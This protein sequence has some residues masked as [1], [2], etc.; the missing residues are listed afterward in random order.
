M[1]TWSSDLTSNWMFNSLSILGICFQKS[2]KDEILE[3]W[4]LTNLMRW[5][6]WNTD[7]SGFRT[8][9]FILFL[10]CQMI[11]DLYFNDG[12][13]NWK[14]WSNSSFCYINQWLCNMFASIT[15]ICWIS[16]LDV[17]ILVISINFLYLTTSQK[18]SGVDMHLFR[19]WQL[20]GMAYFSFEL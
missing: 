16:R 9:F 2:L 3:W 18:N 6:F 20:K 12:T 13:L 17:F 5:N 7:W 4:K 10:W 19:F 1:Y 14:Y 8:I 15:N 11:P